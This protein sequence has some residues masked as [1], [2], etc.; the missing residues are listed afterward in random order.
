MPKKPD[1]GEFHR[2]YKGMEIRARNLKE[3]NSAKA[4]I[5]AYLTG[6]EAV[7]FS[8]ASERPLKKTPVEN[9][10]DGD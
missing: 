4:K 7:Q 6:K 8:H 3:L 1:N 2:T 9:K 5:D 10:A